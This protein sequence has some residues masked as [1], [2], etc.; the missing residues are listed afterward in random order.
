MSKA[1]RHGYTRHLGNMCSKS[2]QKCLVWRSMKTMEE[3]QKVSN[4][5]FND[6]II[7]SKFQLERLA[8][9]SIWNRQTR[10]FNSLL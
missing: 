9:L 8:L 7:F 3:G 2:S 6:Y 5:G 4:V 10:F 1:Q